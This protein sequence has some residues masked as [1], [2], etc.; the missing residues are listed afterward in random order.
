ME[1]KESAPQQQESG[2]D[3]PKSDE[4]GNSANV[5]NKSAIPDV[6]YVITGEALRSLIDER[7][8]KKPK[9]WFQT[10][11]NNALI[12]VVLGGAI[13]AGLTHYY[14]SQQKELEF[15]HSIHLQKLSR[16]DDLNKIRIQKVAELLEQL[17]KDER[18]IDRL[19]DDSLLEGPVSDA[20]SNKRADEIRKLVDDDQA[21]ASRNRFWLGEKGYLKVAEYLDRSVQLALNKLMAPSG[22]DL[23]K[24]ISKREAAKQEVIQSL[25]LESLFWEGDTNAQPANVNK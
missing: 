3:T 21:L 13:T 10:I 11:S 16:L 9:S 7:I 23:S 2:L 17:A 18:A 20:S 19:L 15:R 24:L 6:S 14:T 12:V 22:T 4:L 5:R 1:P 8:E 25:Y